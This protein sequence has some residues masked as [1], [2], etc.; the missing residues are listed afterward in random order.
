[1]LHSNSRLFDLGS[2]DFLW[3]KSTSKMR[4]PLVPIPSVAGVGYTKILKQSFVTQ[5]HTLWGDGHLLWMKKNEHSWPSWWKTS[6]RSTWPKYSKHYLRSVM[7]QSLYKQYQTSF[8]YDS[9]SLK[10]RCERFIQIKILISGLHISHWWPTLI[11]NTWCLPVSDSSYFFLS[12]FLMISS[13]FN[14][15][16]ESGIC[17]DGVIWTRGWAPVGERTNQVQHA[18]ATHWF[19]VIPAVALAGLVACTILEENV[20]RRNFE[21]Y[22]EH[23]LVS[24]IV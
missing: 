14:H 19:N 7:C 24:L 16:D 22:L 13:Y 5:P 20:N 8:I 15:P 11:Q 23:I 10:R 1:M 9:I 6:L 3:S 17:C 12:L 4:P 21:F 18:W 2:M